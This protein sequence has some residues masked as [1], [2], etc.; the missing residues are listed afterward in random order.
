MKAKVT[1]VVQLKHTEAKEYAHYSGPVSFADPA[2]EEVDFHQIRSMRDIFDKKA[3]S[4][5]ALDDMPLELDQEPLG[6]TF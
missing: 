1:P 6:K 2:V 4:L 5:S 3:P